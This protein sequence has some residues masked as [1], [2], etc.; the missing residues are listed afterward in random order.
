MAQT[1]ALHDTI[2]LS[3]S[4]S[5]L[6]T[7]QHRA[8]LVGLVLVIEILQKLGKSGIELVNCTEQGAEIRINELGLRAILDE[9]YAATEELQGRENALKGVEP[10]QTC[11]ETVL[12]KHGK[13]KVRK[14]YYYKVIVPRGSLLEVRDQ[15]EKKLWI[16]L[17][18]DMTWQVLRGV[19]ATRKPFEDRASG[20]VSSDVASL[21]KQLNQDRERAIELPSTY[22]LGAQAFNAERVPFKDNGRSQF[23]L[24]F[25]PLVCQVYVPQSFDREGNRSSDGFALAVPDVARL[26]SFK[27]DYIRVLEHRSSQALGFRP[28][29]AVVDIPAEAGL[30]MVRRLNQVIAEGAGGQETSD[31]FFGIDIFHIRRDGNNVRLLYTARI[32]PSE[33]RDREYVRLKDCL[34]SSLFKHQRLTNLVNEKRWYEGMDSLLASLPIELGLC[35]AYFSH[36]VRACMAMEEEDSKGRQEMKLARGEPVTSDDVCLET[37]I[38]RIIDGYVRQKLRD[39]YDLEWSK[40]SDQNKKTYNDKREGLI[41][42]SF[43]AMRSRTGEDFVNYFASTICS[44]PHWMT[45]EEYACVTRKLYEDTERVR[46]L[47]MLALSARVGR[48]RKEVEPENGEEK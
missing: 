48:D 30:D 12:D 22:F 8:G 15:T 26:K 42:E 36:D 43:Y 33:A 20:K 40:V 4:L 31:V 28:A 16:K 23:L 5:E 45:Q 35:S 17:W 2:E 34:I 44:V 27:S 47:S 18:R 3:Y 38:L 41:K 29:E 32:E 37:L 14:V 21:W 24:H 13:E 19:P 25:W 6:P 7:S 46:A 9:V 10:A 11:D 39:K 1:A